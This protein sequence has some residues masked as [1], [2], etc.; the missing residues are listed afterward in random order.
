MLEACLQALE[1]ANADSERE[2]KKVPKIY[3][4]ISIIIFELQKQDAEKLEDIF[5]Q[6]PRVWGFF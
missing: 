2:N 5:Q 6:V 1:E 4:V 3:S